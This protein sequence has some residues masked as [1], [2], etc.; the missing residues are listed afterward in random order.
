MPRTLN[1]VTCRSRTTQNDVSKQQSQIQNFIAAGVDAIIVNPVDT[2]ATAA[3]SEACCR[4]PRFRWST[5]TAQPVN[6]DTLAGQPGLRRIER[7]GVR[8]AGNQGSLPPISVA[9]ARPWS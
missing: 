2:D 4:Q 6:V 9:R 1:G 3:M 5:S 7:A 8:H